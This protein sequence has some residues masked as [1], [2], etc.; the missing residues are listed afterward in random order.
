MHAA[1]RMSALV[2]KVTIEMLDWIQWPAMAV[3]VIAAWMVGSQKKFKRNW[4]FWLFLLSNV[5]W[6]VWGWQDGAYALIVL[7]L[8]LAFLNIRG[9]LKNRTSEDEI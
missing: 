2:P 9:A 4:G 3:T 6:I 5:L 8:C 1:N 7:Q